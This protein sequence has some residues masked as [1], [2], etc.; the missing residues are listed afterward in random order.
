LFNKVNI[1]YERQLSNSYWHKITKNVYLLTLL[2]YGIRYK[3]EDELTLFSQH[4]LTI[5]SMN[6]LIFHR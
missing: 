1:Q 6:K 5:V 2:S 3:L 4:V